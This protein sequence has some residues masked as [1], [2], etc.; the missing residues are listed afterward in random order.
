MRKI[1]FFILTTMIL[2]NISFAWDFIQYP[3][4]NNGKPVIIGPDGKPLPDLDEELPE[5]PFVPTVKEFLE[6]EDGVRELEKT[7]TVML[8]AK[9]N[10]FVPLEILSDIDL[11]ATVIDDQ[12]IKVPFDIMFNR[13][14]K[15]DENYM[16]RFSENEIDIDND[17]NIDT[18]I[19]APAHIKSKIIT[20]SYVEIEGSKIS[21]EGKHKKRVYITVEVPDGYEEQF[22]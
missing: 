16:L 12:K 11:K 22:L 5:L 4:N 21:K 17:G 1:I 18:T 7:F 2:V 20:E 19:Y 13:E 8:Q 3:G 9:V 15:K 14:P 10:V 6:E